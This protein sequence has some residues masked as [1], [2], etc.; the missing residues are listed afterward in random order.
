MSDTRI[1]K[2]YDKSETTKQDSFDISSTRRKFVATGLAGAG[3]AAS[4]CLGGAGDSGPTIGVL[5]DRSGTF[6][7]I[8]EPKSKASTLA[9]EE[10]NNQGGIL[11]EEIDLF[12]PDPQ[13]DPQ[14]YQQLT[15]Q[16]IQ[17]ENV[18]ALFATYA[19][20]HREAI[21]PII[22]ENEQLY[23]YTTQ[24]EGGVCDSYTF[25][26]GATARQQI[27]KVMPF[28]TEEFG[29]DIYTLAPDYNFGT[30]SAEWVDV[31]A[32][33]L[34]AEVIGEEFFPET[35]SEFGSTINR[36]QQADP[37]Y[38]M[39]FLTGRNQLSFYDQRLAAG[40]EAIPIGT[41]TGMMDAYEHI[42]FNPPAFGGVYA[43][44]NY[45]EEIDTPLNGDFVDRFY[46]R[47]DDAEYINASA[48]TAYYSIYLYKEAVERAGTFD[49]PAV[50]S[51]LENGIEMETIEGDIRL[52]GDTHHVSHQMRIA[53]ADD[54]HNVT[55]QDQEL[56]DPVF[57]QDLGCDLTQEPDSTQYE[58]SALY[59]L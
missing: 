39:S 24:Y 23:F 35:E 17:E 31:I 7:I 58:P 26:T 14:R 2:Y 52:N 27:G 55:F 1:G 13:S 41:T 34:G 22:N 5:E 3:V 18:D 16:A 10:I 40:I 46:D 12:D 53:A 49:Q 6:A 29:T 38:I 48:G 11:G 9:V 8:G 59:D 28:L 45:M 43:P 51:E 21:R 36:I 56:I 42:R 20:P 30:L 57:M 33:E 15:R 32:N 47:F 54:D 44:T 19:S 37:D 50:I 25:C 4:G